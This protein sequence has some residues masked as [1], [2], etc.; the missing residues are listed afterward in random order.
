MLSNR[1][2]RI[3]LFIH[4]KWFFLFAS[5]SLKTSEAK[6]VSKKCFQ[7]AYPPSISIHSSNPTMPF[8]PQDTAHMQLALALAWQ[9]RFSTSPN[10][11]V[12]CVIAHGSQIVGQGYHVQAGAPH[13]EV[14]ALAQAGELARGATAYV[15]LEPCAHHGRTPPCAEALVRA[16][17][18]RVIA[19]MQDP[20][21]LVAGKGLAILRQAGI[22]VASGLCEAEARALNRGF[23]SRIER[24]RPF[25]KL[26]IAAS[27]DGKT[28]LA[29][30]DSKWITGEAA[31][32]DV[33]IQR[34]ESCAVLTG[35][36]TILADNPQLNIRIPTIRQPLRIVLDR[37][38]R[39]PARS[40]II[41]DGGNTLI[42]TQSHVNP[43]ADYPNVQIHRQPENDL[44]RL[45]AHLAQ[46]HQIGELMVEAGSIRATAFI[47]AD[48]AD[49]IV[50]YQAPKILGD[51]ARGLFRL[52]ENENTLTRPSKWQTVSVEAL[53]DDIKWVLQRKP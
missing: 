10:P 37:Q 3:F 5:G 53:G 14:H 47:Q 35:I 49:E 31:R 42:C 43:F 48:L 16:G 25:V 17:V 27:L 26:K 39:T 52:P 40:R 44:P 50:Y 23:L 20:N 46:Q 38:L 8:T 13:A 41:Q 45:L 22:Q 6:T 2:G 15:T 51:S 4:V 36:G 12:G 19:A 33:Q 34:A 29:N 11:R 24:Q 30:G 7:A 32:A 28:A 1:A 9:G 18:S 21:P